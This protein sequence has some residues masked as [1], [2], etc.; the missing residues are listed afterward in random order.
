[1]TT[2][3]VAVRRGAP[4]TPVPDLVSDDAEPAHDLTARF[5]PRT[6]T[7]GNWLGG[8]CAATVP[9]GDARILWL[10]NDT[11]KGTG[12]GPWN[13]R[14]GAQFVNDSIAIQSGPDLATAGLEFLFAPGGGNWFTI[15]G[16]THYAWPEGGIVLDGDLY[17]TS[18]RILA[19]AGE[20]YD[21][22]WCLHKIPAALTTDPAAWSPTLLYQSGDTD[23]RPILSLYDGLDGYVYAF[24]LK[25][26]HGWRWARW[27]R[28]DF[29][30]GLGGT[31]TWNQIFSWATDPASA[32]QL[33]ES[34]FAA[35]GSVHKRADGRWVIVESG[36]GRVPKHLVQARVCEG[37]SFAPGNF[38]YPL[39]PTFQVGDRV[40]ETA[41]GAVGTITAASGA[42]RTVKLD[43]FSGGGVITRTTAQL[44][45]G[46]GTNRGIYAPLE[47]FVSDARNYAAK[48]HPALAGPGLVCSYVD[49]RPWLDGFGTPLSGGLAYDLGTYSPKF[50]RVRP[51]QP[52][53]LAVAGGTASWQMRG[54]PD[55]LLIQAGGGAWT[56][57]DPSALSAPVTGTPVALR[58][59]GVGGDTV[60]TT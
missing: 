36:G 16:G 6:G 39:P 30:A 18:K 17:V 55:R 50:I 35:D 20:S 54:T 7:T 26:R 8:D 25:L 15:P 21:A 2:P 49:S 32:F 47:N 3:Q 13:D 34:Y 9:L 60:V 42:N 33:A 27:A 48:A 14:V 10:F 38:Y 57:L 22:G 28:A 1:M 11:F 29:T 12:T 43:A 5:D 23:T 19:S 52:S 40:A 24:G 41:T 4:F 45:L 59:I 53:G 31:V 46:T 56:E 37:P 51:P 44:T 58:A